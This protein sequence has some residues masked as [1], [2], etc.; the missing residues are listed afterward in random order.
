M[1]PPRGFEPRTFKLT[2]YCSAV[3]L[4][5]N[6]LTCNLSQKNEIFN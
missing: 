6:K 1:A 2:A 4:Q 5:G 3:E